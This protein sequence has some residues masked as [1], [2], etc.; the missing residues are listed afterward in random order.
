MNYIEDADQGI[1]PAKQMPDAK[2]VAKKLFAKGISVEDFQAGIE[3]SGLNVQM[4]NAV[5]SELVAL[6]TEEAG[7]EKLPDPTGNVNTPKKAP[8]EPSTKTFVA[9]NPSLLP[10]EENP[11]QTPTGSPVET[12]SVT[13]ITGASVKGDAAY[14]IASEVDMSDWAITVS[15]MY[16]PERSK[17]ANKEIAKL[18]NLSFDGDVNYVEALLEEGDETPYQDALYQVGQ[19]LHNSIMTQGEKDISSAESPEQVVTLLERIREDKKGV[20][21]LSTLRSYSVGKIEEVLPE[22]MGYVAQRT[23]QRMI[24]AQEIGKRE[25]DIAEKATFFDAFKDFGEIATPFGVGTLSEEIKKYEGDTINDLIVRIAEEQDFDTQ[26]DIL[27]KGLD[28]WEAQETYFFER[29]NSL[30]TRAQLEGV[31]E[32]ITQGALDLEEG[33]MSEQAVKQ[34][35]ETLV[36]AGFEVG[37]VTA[38]FR[39]VSNLIGFVSRRFNPTTSQDISP[40]LIA[41]AFDPNRPSP[42]TT[43]IISY[44]KAPFYVDRRDALKESAAKKDTRL[45]RKTLAN[46]KRDLGRFK[47]QLRNV[48]VNKE[49]RELA[50]EKKIKFKEALKQVKADIDK[51]FISAENRLRTVQEKIDAFDV[52]AQA[53]GELSRIAQF[54]KDGRLKEEDLLTKGGMKVVP[55]TR[56]NSNIVD[57]EYLEA[58]LRKS[59]LEQQ[60]GLKAVQEAN[61]L[62]V[63]DTV[64]RQ[65]PTPNDQAEGGFNN[66]IDNNTVL[67]DITLMDND[68][69]S[70]GM[71]LARDVERQAGTSLEAKHS[72]TKFLGYKDDDN[73]IGVYTFRMQDGARGGFSS[74]VDAEEAASRGLAGTEYKIVEENGQFFAE[75][76]VEHYLNPLNDVTGFHIDYSK[77]IGP[78]AG[79]L[80]PTGQRTLGS[81]VLKGLQALKSVHRSRVQKMENKY[82]AAVKGLSYEQGFLLDSALK[83]GADEQVA[84]SNS[85]QFKK[86]TSID[87]EA[88][89]NAYRQMREI[90]DETWAIRN[91]NYY[92]K[93]RKANLK[94]VDDGLDGNLGKVLNPNSKK[95]LKTADG[96]IYDVET[97]Q[98]VK[99]DGSKGFSYVRL[100]E[101]VKHEGGTLRYVARV[102]SER[103]KPLPMNLLNKKKG[104]IDRYYRD[105]GWLVQKSRKANVEGKEVDIKPQITHIVGSE[106]DAK[107]I[108]EREGG[109]YIRARE[110]DELDEI[111]ATSD[112]VQ[113]TYGSSH[114]KKKGEMLKGPDGGDANT[115]NTFESMG[116][117]IASTQKAFDYNMMETLKARFYN[118]FG[119]LL[120][121]KKATPFKEKVGDMF[122]KDAVKKGGNKKRLQE[123]TNWHQYIRM[124]ENNERAALLKSIDGAV[125]NFFDP[126]LNKVGR[127]TDSVAALQ[128]FRKTVAD[129]VVVW[130]PLYQ[131]KQNLVPAMY[132]ASTKGTDG[133]LGSLATAGLRKALKGDF[134]R[135]SKILGITE[136]QSKVMIDELRTSG[137]IDAVGRSND[138]L[139]LARGDL[140]VGA[141]T[142]GKATKQKT[143]KYLGGLAYD[144][145]KKGQEASIVLMNLISYMAEFR[146]AVKAGEPLTGKTKATISFRAQKN[147]QSQNSMDMFWFQDS[148]SI[149]GLAF[150]MYQHMYKVFLDVVLEPQYRTL[151]GAAEMIIK[152]ELSNNAGKVIGKEAGGFAE[153][154]AQALVTSFV[155]YG[156]WGLKGGMGENIGGFVEDKVREYF[157][158]LGNS[159]MGNIILNGGWNETLNGA[160]RAL[161]GEGAVDLTST[162]GPAG[163]LDMANDF[164]IEGF[165]NFNFAG[166]SGS[167]VGGVAESLGSATALAV[168]PNIDTAEKAMAIASELLEPLQGVK[169][170]DKA[171]VA[172]AFEQMPFASSLSGTQKV[173]AIEGILLASNIQPSLVMDDFRNADFAKRESS[174]WDLFNGKAYTTFVTEAMMQAFAREMARTQVGINMGIF[175]EISF[176][177]RQA[178]KEKWVEAAKALVPESRY[179]DVEETFRRRALGSRT[180]TYETYLRPAI[181][182]G[183]AGSYEQKLDVMVQKANSKEARDVFLAEKETYKRIDDIAKEMDNR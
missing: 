84:W 9:S 39:S 11:V 96:L 2:D 113:F 156:A 139:D 137:L 138:F 99:P 45:Y 66:P 164:I 46:E 83:K 1:I 61:G 44:E 68:Q 67:N 5:M 3:A 87:D 104:H 31:R 49:A 163:L 12:S 133:I 76:K 6:E 102:P 59:V 27:Q 63:E 26:Q 101:P 89:F 86:A 162:Y 169:N 29:N 158:E 176:K 125:S 153:T 88:V 144:A 118:E 13:P 148:K 34:Y 174:I 10:R 145:S 167:V 116:R 73:S 21:S 180:P 35:V 92:N 140:D 177:E 16:A 126:L 161:G 171:V 30:L 77:T 50:K 159:Q 173:T 81:E 147:L 71:R 103:V 182:S 78:I 18:V 15:P 149:V 52:S 70:I 143:K 51:S 152:R 98:L 47:E 130:N 42:Y 85:A 53:E 136:E 168:T 43:N 106:A 93:V 33:T 69:T 55:T 128:S 142:L 110:N 72:D 121:E 150:Q 179:A 25:A 74:Y 183:E 119:D 155:T 175:D 22:R 154:Y 120:A 28:A 151:T 141:T 166:V 115:L 17:Q 56:R 58:P 114:T 32:A 75:V 131:I 94:F 20:V 95:D 170:I 79:K 91:K 109:D 14:S 37:V 157:P 57:T 23:L 48:E 19:E 117:T 127:T 122:S 7:N 165:P 4:D 90:Y 111:F 82:K 62:S 108:A 65:V 80:L 124:L 60:G 112:D 97:K 36:N 132:L 38:A 105:T 181:E 100:T 134:T 54:L 24:L 160:I 135:I 40:D 146:K 107:R 8:V 172:Y 123:A 41:R 64:M 178:I 129:L